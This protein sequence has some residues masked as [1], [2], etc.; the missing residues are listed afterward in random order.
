M[1]TVRIIPA[2]ATHAL[3]QMVLRPHQPIEEMRYAGDDDAQTVHFG[4]FDD[5]GELRA[6]ASLY[7]SPIGKAGAA[8]TGFDARIREQDHWQFRGVASVPEVRG[9]GFGRLVQAALTDHARSHGCG[10]LWC[11][12]RLSAVGFY[13][14]FGMRI[15]SGVFEI[16]GIGPHVVMFVHLAPTKSTT[17]GM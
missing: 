10:L 11:N 2:H 16:P 8:A 13:E 15:A 17:T 4:A 6:I 9:R 5:A 14:A 1:P 3:R 7:R 12:A